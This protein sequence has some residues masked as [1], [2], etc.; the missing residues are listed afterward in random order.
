MAKSTKPKSRRR[1]LY[2]KA[3]HLIGKL[4]D[5]TIPAGRDAKAVLRRI[6]AAQRVPA[7]S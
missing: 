7:I 5:P 2:E 1:S 6:F 4:D 3:K